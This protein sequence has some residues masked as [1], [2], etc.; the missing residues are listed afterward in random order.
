MRQKIIL[1]PTHGQALAYRKGLARSGVGAAFGVKATTYSSWLADAWALYGDGRA[2]ASSLDRT[3]AVRQLLC[4]APELS[5][6]KLTDGGV[7]LVCRFL[8]DALGSS[9]LEECLSCPPT[10]LSPQERAIL[11]LVPLYRESLDSRGLVDPGDALGFLA[12]A[13]APCSFALAEG[14]CPSLAFDDFAAAS[15]STVQASPSP[16]LIG[17]V[18]EGCRPVFLLAAGPS[19]ENALVSGWLSDFLDGACSESQASRV[20]LCTSRPFSVFEAVS[21]SLSERAACSL[22]AKRP[23]AQT[24]FGRAFLAVREY[25]HGQTHD[26]MALMDYLS[27]PFSGV[28]GVDV[29]K[30]YSQVRG[31]RTLGF[32][33]LHAMAHLLSPTFDLFEELVEDCDASLLLDRFLDIAEEL[34]GLDAAEAFEQQVAISALRG[35]YEA[36]RTW[37]VPPSG[38][39]FAL[40]GL[41]LDASRACG[42]GPA[43][44]QVV[45]VALVD[46]LS[47]DSFDAVVVCDLDARYWSA[48]ESH[49]AI[50]GLEEKLGI[51]P[52]SHAL[53]D[54]RR[55]FEGL[56]SRAKTVFACER[57]LNAGGDEDV[58]PSFVLDEFCAALRQGPADELD[59]NGIPTSLSSAVI[60]RNEGGSASTFSAN[61][62]FGGKE[63]A[64]FAIPGFA[65]GSLSDGVV[66]DLS[67]FRAVDDPSLLVLSP[68]AIEE[69][70]NC[71]Y[72]WFASRRLRPQPPD[73]L[74]GPL[75]QGVFVHS[76]LEAFYSRIEKE[77]GA[78]RVG[79]QNLGEAQLLMGHVFDEVL[80]NQPGVQDNARFIPLTPVERARASRLK[81]TLCRNL[82]V[83]AQLMPS[84]HPELL[85]C[86]VQ[87]DQAIDYAGVRIMGRADRVD[88]D[89]GRGC[90]AVIDYK[91]GVAGHEAGMDPDE[92]EEVC[93]PSKIQALVYAQV[94]ARGVLDAKPVGALYLSYRAFEAKGSVA[95]SYD[96]ALLDLQGFAGGR[97]SVKMNFGSYLD[98]IEALVG[99]KLA[100]L[101]E[102]CIEPDPLTAQS[103]R[104]C[105]V[106]NCARRL[107]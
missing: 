85:E 47:E 51:P 38:L 79:L 62:D 44:V 84:F 33:D 18:A 73:E 55:R 22:R 21:N 92:A 96:E 19:C 66:A 1:F 67:L 10:S 94:I 76:V 91:G 23:F 40:Q 60:V 105:P 53:S 99:E 58:Y 28:S 43:Q 27:S 90:F 89:P 83:Q 4:D 25:L 15:R 101:Y 29:A 41:S 104:Y 61:F 106:A 5:S 81:Q 6:L 17:A 59:G 78:K 77:L 69:Y 42:S 32:D 35:I 70:V 82:G 16:S 63:P 26:P 102:G 80:A 56:K 9:R 68:S 57:V 93:L 72:R 12:D 39:S 20:L 98:S 8:T 52:R 103:C 107:S 30:V 86:Q 45:D 48:G 31:D 64:T 34:E 46:Q 36:A 7:S 88:V 74:L 95:G 54:A 97:S 2:L 50:V 71:P 100:R 14:V 24:H 87:P 49:N 37:G 13:C 65:P 75:E 11:A 3:F